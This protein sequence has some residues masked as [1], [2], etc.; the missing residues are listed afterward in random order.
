MCSPAAVRVASVQRFST[1]DG[2]GI[3][4]TLFL[5]GCNLRCPWCHNPETV[6]AERRLMFWQSL[7]TS[8][9]GCARA[10]PNGAHSV[11]ARTHAL[12]GSRC[13][14]CG[15][16]VEACPS[17]A[18][19]MNGYD[20]PFSE[21]EGLCAVLTADREYYEATGGGVTF[22]GGE[23]LLQAEAVAE[24]ARLCKERR[25]HTLLDTAACV[26]FSAFEPS[27]HYIDEYYIDLKCPSDEAYRRLTGGSLRPVLDSMTRLR[28][29]GKDVTA[30]IPIIPGVN[31]TSDC[32]E[33]FS[34]LL[35]P[36]GVRRVSLLPFHRLGAG[37]YTALGRR[38]A[39]AKTPPLMPEALAPLSACF[40]SS[41][42]AAVQGLERSDL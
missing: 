25:I 42:H 1:E 4:T 12:D 5:R 14:G 23:P 29:L 33:A 34:A 32:C 16:C 41:L 24:L 38:Y 18:L 13:A 11:N 39:Y 3:R 15:A 30:R 19:V 37:K 6:P 36:T 17:A 27:L 26:D 35:L 8:C 28:A 20:V 10:C 2:R 40:D 31:D 9:G 7:C 22:S 21:L